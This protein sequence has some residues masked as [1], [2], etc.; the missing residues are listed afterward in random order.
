MNDENVYRHSRM[1][2]KH[3][4]NVAMLQQSCSS[5]SK[6]KQCNCNCTF[7]GILNGCRESIWK[8]VH[9][10]PFSQQ[11]YIL[12]YLSY[13]SYHF[14]LCSNCQRYTQI[15]C[16]QLATNN[17]KHAIF[18][19]KFHKKRSKWYHGLKFSVTICIS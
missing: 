15:H 13:Q 4:E 14:K 8:W 1:C 19:S 9:Q 11:H 17:R 12:V 16:V 10:N 3:L 5:R 6:K 18:T 2:I 7:T